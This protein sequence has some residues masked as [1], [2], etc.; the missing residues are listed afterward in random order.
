MY[1]RPLHGEGEQ[2]QVSVDGGVE[3]VWSPDSRELFYRA[4][5]GSK[6]MMTAATVSTSPHLAITSRKAL[7]PVAEYSMATPHSN[8]GVSPDG[9]TLVLVGFNQAARVVII[10][11]LP[12][13]V[14]RLTAGE[15]ES[16]P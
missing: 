16:K 11:N 15:Q 12:G 7:L 9:K 14:R 6:A 4:G 3:P 1:V 5:A 2:V 13:L 8:Y 10:Q